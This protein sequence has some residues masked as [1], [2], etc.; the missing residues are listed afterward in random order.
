MSASE[1]NSGIPKETR[2][3]CMC[4]KRCGGPSNGRKLVSLHCRQRHVRNEHIQPPTSFMALCVQ[5]PDAPPATGVT[6]SPVESGMNKR[7]HLD[8]VEQHHI[9]LGSLN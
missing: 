8:L 7:S 1:L 4:T 5:S 3:C 6:A 9:A 2:V